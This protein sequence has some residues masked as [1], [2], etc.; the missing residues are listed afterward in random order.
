MASLSQQPKPADDELERH[1]ALV[2]RSNSSPQGVLQDTKKRQLYSLTTA[3]LIS[4]K[5]KQ[6]VA[7]SLARKGDQDL[8]FDM[9]GLLGLRTATYDKDRDIASQ[10]P[11]S[12]LDYPSGQIQTP[13]QDDP[14]ADNLLYS[15]TSAPWSAFICGQQGAGKSY[16]MSCLLE[17]ALLQ[18]HALGRND[19][20][21]TGLVFHY[22]KH[23]AY[24]STQICEAAFLCTKGVKVEVL[25]SPTNFAAMKKE[26]HN[27]ERFGVSKKELP[28]VRPLLFD[29]AMLSVDYM[30]NLMNQG[31]SDK[32]PLYMATV[33]D[34]VREMKMLGQTF[35]V[36]SFKTRMTQ[37][38]MK[39]D[40]KA[41]FDQRMALLETFMWSSAKA[42]I[43]SLANGERGL[44]S[45]PGQLTIVDLS[46]STIGEADVCTFYEMCLS[47]F[48]ANREK[49]SSLLVGIDEAHKFL[50]ETPEAKHLT[51]ELVRLIRQLRHL[52][53]RV[54]I[55]T[56][57]PTLAPELM[58]LCDVSIIHRFR[59]PAWFSAIK[60]HLAGLVWSGSVGG[61]GNGKEVFERIEDSDGSNPFYSA[62]EEG[63]GGADLDDEDDTLAESMAEL[64]LDD[65]QRLQK[66][67]NALS[68]VQPLNTKYIK[69]QI[70]QRLTTDGGKSQMASR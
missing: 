6:H 24:E 22:D 65:E 25:V 27:S 69:V 60:D 4:R 29:D 11:I 48:L 57:E 50:T 38:G 2:G 34:V 1:L 52:K 45:T 32:L 53:S 31:D 28:K 56:Q 36:A 19:N 54:L 39:P 35:T 14:I 46:C 49:T 63:D 44:K 16:T 68:K 30:L 64:G 42:V 21:L 17:N 62:S 13:M 23:A 5:V 26:Y 41:M 18:G 15:N 7:T 10:N 55:A 12:P 47:M 43:R 58:D 8:P 67:V 37:R 40:Q 33:V 59:S 20:P 66:Q 9:Y 51:E 70:R 3:P 61:S